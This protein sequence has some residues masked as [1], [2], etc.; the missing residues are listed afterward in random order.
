L[1]NCDSREIQAGT[2]FAKKLWGG[3]NLVVCISMTS[4]CSPN[5]STTFLQKW[6]NWGHIIGLTPG[7]EH[8]GGIATSSAYKYT[9]VRA[10]LTIEQTGRMPRA[11]RLNIKTL[12]YCFLMLLGRSPRVKIVE[13][14]V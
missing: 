13:L 11:S 7:Y 14:F 5:R 6:P 1:K 9:T 3:T 10:G 8:R 2:V 12:I 4:P